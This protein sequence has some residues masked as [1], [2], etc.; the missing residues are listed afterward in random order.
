MQPDDGF[1]RMMQP[2]NGFGRM[3]Q[4][5]VWCERQNDAALWQ[6][7]IP[8]IKRGPSQIHATALLFWRSVLI[9]YEDY[10]STGVK[11]DFSAPQSGHTQSSGRSSKAVPGAIPLSGS[12][13]A[14]SYTYPQGP[15]SYFFMSGTIL[16]FS[17][18][19]AGREI[20]R[21]III[22]GRIHYKK[23]DTADYA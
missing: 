4:L 18:L 19:S 10:S 15:P 3:M 9:S 1:R 11:S 6:F 20:Y 8:G 22:Q 16:S 7:G 21:L 14:G 23:L 17:R 2:D 13:A 5:A 12:P